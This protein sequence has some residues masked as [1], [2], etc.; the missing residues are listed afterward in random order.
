MIKYLLNVVLGIIGVII[1]L[2]F[3]VMYGLACLVLGWA[4]DL[5][6]LTWVFITFG[7]SSAI[8]ILSISLWKFTQF[9]E[10]I[11]GWI[12][13]PEL[14]LGKLWIS[15]LDEVTFQGFVIGSMVIGLV[16]IILAC[17]ES[18]RRWYIEVKM[19]EVDPLKK[20]AHE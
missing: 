2:L 16:F 15:L 19:T 3:S 18:G 14:F 12:L 11:H 10:G 6:F 7:L 4:P 20:S 1:L 13:I 17:F 8:L 5:S 9:K